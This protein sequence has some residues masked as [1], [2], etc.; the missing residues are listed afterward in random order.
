MWSTLWKS[1]MLDRMVYKGK[2]LL[3]LRCEEEMLIFYRPLSRQ[4][5]LLH[6]LAVRRKLLTLSVYGALSRQS[7][8]LD[9]LVVR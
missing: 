2:M 5:P 8:W 4:S 6:R 7:S 9:G 3:F 1:A